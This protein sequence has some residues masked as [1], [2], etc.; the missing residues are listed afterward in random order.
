MHR[1]MNVSK[2]AARDIGKFYENSCIRINV[3]R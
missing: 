2:T 3:R 1:L